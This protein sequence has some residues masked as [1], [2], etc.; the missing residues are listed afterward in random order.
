MPAAAAA[1]LPTDWAA[2]HRNAAHVS[3]TFGDPAVTVANAGSLSQRW[4]FTALPATEPNQPARAFDASPTVVGNRVYIGSRTGMFYAL[5][6]TTGAVVWQKQL[7]WGSAEYCPAKG[8]VGTATVMQDPVDGVLTVYAPGAH[9]LYALNAAT[10]AQRWKRSIGPNTAAGNGLFFNWSSPTVAGGRVFMGLAANCG[11]RPIRAGAL[12]I[13]QHTGAWQNT[14]H[15]VPAGTVGASVWSSQASNG[16]YVWVTTGNPDPTGTTI[17]DAYSIVRLLA[18]TMAK[19]DKW[20]A[21]LGQTADLDF[22]SS[23]TLFA[24][25]LAG[26]ETPMVGACNKNGV[27]YAWRRWNL[28]AG[29]IWSRLVGTP[30]G[31]DEGSCIT[32]AAWDYTSRRLFVAANTTTIGGVESWGGLRALNPDTGAVVWARSLPCRPTG[33]PTINGQVVA[34]PMY[35]CPTG[36]APSVL[37]FRESDGQ[38]LGSVPATGRTFA[39]PVFAAGMLL[40]ASQDGTLTAYRP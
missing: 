7:D 16:N 4:Q 5:N 3:A 11:S 14:W 34:V 29:P 6:A 27:Y 19:E 38:P 2:F 32:S 9:F 40:V 8:I 18:S 13:N 22:G 10:G 37:L 1:P 25:T 12:A 20:T 21:P 17:D 24:A 26:A 28:A 31:G 30:G 39:Q 15:A 23:P 33:S 36:V 35:A